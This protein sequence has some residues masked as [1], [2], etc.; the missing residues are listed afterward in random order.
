MKNYKDKLKRAIF[1][2]ETVIELAVLAVTLIILLFPVKTHE[3]R[4]Y[5]EVTQKYIPARVVSVLSEELNDSSYSKGGK[6]GSQRLLVRLRGGEEVELT[7][8]ISD[9]HNI[10]AREGMRLTV[11]ADVPENSAPYYTVY[12]Y[13]RRGAVAALVI[14][15]MAL[16]VAVGKRKGFDAF[17]AIFFSLVF[18]L[19]VAL[20]MLYNGN[21]AIPVGLITALA[22]TAV[23]VLLIH[24]FTKQCAYGIVTTLIGELAACLIF[25]VFAG[26]L[27]ITGFQVEQAEN[28]LLI[29]RHTGLDIKH[30]LMAGM[31]ISSLGAV[32]DVAVSVLSSLREIALAMEKPTGTALFVSGMNI[33]RDL[34]GT[35]ANTLIFAFV[36]G[37]L[38]SM[39]VFYSWGVQVSQLLS[40]DYLAVE[41]AQGICST[42]AV[43]L[44]VP[45]AAVIGALAFGRRR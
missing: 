24:G 37:S 27:H 39:L 1:S 31:I 5:G 9:M 26:A 3:F 17:L 14:A 23:T 42:M 34:I 43:I 32:M 11:C 7:N 29:T 41:L 33:G 40:S 4:A 22:A 8:Y 28:L 18:I 15:F 6:I 30:L 12:N 2:K 16:T 25:A 36:G 10:I 20:P 21:A 13:D 38:T 45:L 35:M 44:T 19:N